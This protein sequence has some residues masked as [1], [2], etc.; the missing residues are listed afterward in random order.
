MMSDAH[1]VPLYGDDLRPWGVERGYPAEGLAEHGEERLVVAVGPKAGHQLGLDR[2]ADG[3]EA[4]RH[5]VGPG[6]ADLAAQQPPDGGGVG[7]VGHSPERSRSSRASKSRNASA[8]SWSHRSAR[9]RS[10][11]LTRCRY[12]QLAVDGVPLRLGSEL[13]LGE[14][15]HVVVD[16]D[17]RPG[18][19]TSRENR[20]IYRSR[21]HIKFVWVRRWSRK[22]RSTGVTGCP[23]RI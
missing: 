19:V 4:S 22:L 20:L 1:Q 2:R 9:A 6:G 17:Q 21:R 13:L 12:R 5:A 8:F 10:S 3:D 16:V 7:E 11:A 18:H 15:Q 23:C 14:G